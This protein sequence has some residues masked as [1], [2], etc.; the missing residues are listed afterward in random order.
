MT[1]KSKDDNT[2]KKKVAKKRS[3]FKETHLL[4]KE[5]GFCRI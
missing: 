3:P 1:K 5:I 2:K 4:E